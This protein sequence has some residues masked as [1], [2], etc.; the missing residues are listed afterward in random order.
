MAS[1]LEQ[2]LGQPFVVEN[3]P[4]GQTGVQLAAITGAEPDGYTI[5]STTATHIAVMNAIFDEYSIDSVDWI[6][7]LVTD[8]RVLVVH[9]DIPFDSLEGLVEEVKANPG[10]YSV[11]GTVDGSTGHIAWAMFAEAAGIGEDDVRYVPYDSQGD[12]VTA[13]VGGHVPIGMAWPGITRDH[14][15][16]GNLR[17][18][19]VLS[20]ERVSVYPDVPTFTEAGY[21]VDPSWQQF[22]GIIGPKG[23]PEE[24][25]AKLVDALEQVTQTEEYQNYINNSD[26][27][28]R[29]MDSEEFTEFVKRQD[30]I[31]ANWVK[32][33]NLDE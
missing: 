17:V 27:T 33:L 21:D 24:I 18:L 13:N 3:R 2:I 14:V 25:K 11:S 23:I 4:G 1:E 32:R 8:P 31:V 26:L 29:F 12:S 6:A 19:G 20:D 5:G 9:D 7:G 16:A 22:R 30:G 28:D 15:E 10:K